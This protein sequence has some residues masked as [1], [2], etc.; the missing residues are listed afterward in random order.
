[1]SGRWVNS[2]N[3]AGPLVSGKSLAV[4]IKLNLPP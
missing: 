4:M 2:R 3:A 1:M